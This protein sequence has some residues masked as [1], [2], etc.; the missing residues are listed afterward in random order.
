MGKRNTAKPRNAIKNPKTCGERLSRS[1]RC[2]QPADDTP[3][4]RRRSKKKLW[5]CEGHRVKRLRDQNEIRIKQEKR[6]QVGIS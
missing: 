2:G 3:V 1:V 4:H 5:L 6:A